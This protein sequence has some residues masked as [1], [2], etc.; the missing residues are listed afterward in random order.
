MTATYFLA[1]VVLVAGVVMAAGVRY[2]HGRGAT[3]LL[4]GLPLWLVYV[5]TLSYLGVVRDPTVRPPGIVF[6][7]LPVTL[8]VLFLAGSETGG[9][10]AAAFP[11]WLAPGIQTFRIGV[12]LLLH[13]LWADGVVPRM[14]TYDGANPDILIGLSAPFIA[15]AATR[16]QA[17]RRVALVWNLLGLLALA[18]VITRFVLT[19]PGPLHLIPSEV[20]N[21]AMGTFPFTYIA[22][23]LAPLA[24]LLH[25]LFIRELRAAG[26]AARRPAPALAI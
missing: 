18:N 19:T 11:L 13:R 1:F 16:G 3:A 15:W 22:G 20:P 4:A 24:I 23:F 8:F 5:G 10:A 21:L 6:V 9:R 26:K 25:V 14:V 12:E 7:V 2:L 17:G